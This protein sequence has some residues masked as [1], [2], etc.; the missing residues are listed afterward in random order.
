MKSARRGF[1]LIEL[2]VVIAIIALLIGILLPALGRA[3]NAGRLA[4]SMNNC[5]Q[6]LIGQATYRFDKKDLIPMRG[7][8]YNAGTMNG[9]DTW[10][11]GGKNCDKL[12]RTPYAGIFDESAFARPLNPY[13][14]SEISLDQPPGYVNTGSGSA[15]NFN[16]GNASDND[17]E[18]LQMSVYRSPG[19][20]ATYQGTT[21]PLFPYG[22]ANPAR[23][24]YDDVGTSYHFNIKWWDQPG[25]PGNPAAPGQPPIPGTFTQRFNEGV[26]RTR[27]ASEFDP[28]NK[29][30]WIHDQTADVVANTAPTALGVMGEFG[31]K[32]KS[33]HAYLDGRVSYNLMQQ[34]KLYDGSQVGGVWTVTGKYTFIFVLPGGS[35]PPP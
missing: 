12:W 28:T 20:R 2:L 26:R 11:Y 30:V 16:H 13:L 6:V 4:V 35:M 15:W 33:V 9:W 14:Y 1:T 29:F 22:V 8:Q 27:L 7:T 31:E 32:N 10:S 19:D 5:R 17:R 25:M 3:R 34:G 24:S 18:K 21:E 23:S